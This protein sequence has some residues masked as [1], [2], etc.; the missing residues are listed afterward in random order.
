MLLLR[1]LNVSLTSVLL[2]SFFFSHTPEYFKKFKMILVCATGALL[3]AVLLLVGY[4]SLSFYSS[5]GIALQLSLVLMSLLWLHCVWIWSIGEKT[6]RT[7]GLLTANLVFMLPML[8][9]A[10]VSSHLGIEVNPKSNP[11]V[12]TLVLS[13]LLA[14]ME[15]IALSG[16]KFRITSPARAMGC[17]VCFTVCLYLAVEIFTK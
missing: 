11:V 2:G 13:A 8:F 3:A 10:Q 14:C 17:G 7:D 12:L 1:W 5:W 9:F 15:Y 16:R 6:L 4:F